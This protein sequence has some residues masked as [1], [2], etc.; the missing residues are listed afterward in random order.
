MKKADVIF[1]LGMHAVSSNLSVKGEE[2][3]AL[4]F[5]N[6]LQNL[7]IPSDEKY[8]FYDLTPYLPQL[9]L[10]AFEAMRTGTGHDAVFLRKRYEK[11]RQERMVNLLELGEEGGSGV[12][13]VLG[14]QMLQYVLRA[15]VRGDHLEAKMDSYCNAQR[16]ALHLQF[17]KFLRL[18]YQRGLFTIIAAT[19]SSGMEGKFGATSLRTWVCAG[20]TMFTFA[21]P[22][23]RRDE[24]SVSFVAGDDDCLALEA[25]IQSVNASLS[26]GLSMIDDVIRYWPKSEKDQKAVFKAEDVAPVAV[27]AMRAQNQAKAPA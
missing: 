15:I 8:D 17:D 6:W 20:R 27:F 23:K 25:G 10:D 12:D 11:E 26:T 13:Q 5:A 24:V 4:F 1:R 2:T 18:V 19:S 22:K 9:A 7:D 16:H 3:F 21:R 14:V